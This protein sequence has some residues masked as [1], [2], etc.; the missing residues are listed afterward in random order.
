[1][2]FFIESVRTFFEKFVFRQHRKPRWL[3]PPSLKY[4]SKSGHREYLWM[5]YM[6]G[7]GEQGAQ[8]DQMCLWE[9]SPKTWPNTF[10][11]KL[12]HKNLWKSCQKRGLLLHFLKKP[13]QS[14]QSAIGRK[15]TQ[16]G[17]SVKRR[18]LKT[19]YQLR[20]KGLNNKIECV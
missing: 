7:G 9:I 16:S 15:F 18:H 17:H 12:M 3:P 10:W 11:S 13:T 1:V 20:R 4:H 5:S 19:S 8:G 6:C 2:C 14:K